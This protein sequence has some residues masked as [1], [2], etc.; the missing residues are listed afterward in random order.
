MT[1]RLGN[2]NPSGGR[3]IGRVTRGEADTKCSPVTINGHCFSQL[4]DSLCMHQMNLYM[5]K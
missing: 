4:T 5:A 1:G 3:C 2:A